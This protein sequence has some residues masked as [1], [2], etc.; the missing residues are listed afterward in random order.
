MKP[1][2]HTLPRVHVLLDILF[3]IGSIAVSY[4]YPNFMKNVK[5]LLFPI[6][7]GGTWRVWKT[8]T[9]RRINKWMTELF[10]LLQRSV[11]DAHHFSIEWK[12]QILKLI[13]IFLVQTP[14]TLKA[15]VALQEVGQW[16]TFFVSFM[17]MYLPSIFLYAQSLLCKQIC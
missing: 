14:L 15:K 4:G 5:K 17:L 3:I 6:L 16:A 10:F 1:P 7:L 2:R 9:T 12:Y 11:D 8:S 13:F